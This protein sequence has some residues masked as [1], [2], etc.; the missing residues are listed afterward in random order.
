M[1]P[2]LRYYRKNKMK[3]TRCAAIWALCVLMVF[4]LLGSP[5]SHAEGAIPNTPAMEGQTGNTDPD[6]PPAGPAAPGASEA[7]DPGTEALPWPAYDTKD[8]WTMVL[9]EDSEAVRDPLPEQRKVLDP[10]LDYRL[11]ASYANMSFNVPFTWKT[12]GKILLL[13]LSL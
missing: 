12:A 3:G 6:T 13:L 2:T 5:L 7:G 8:R 11:N 10:I 1:K 4:L 9:K